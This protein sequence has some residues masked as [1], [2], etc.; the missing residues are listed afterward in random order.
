MF[1]RQIDNK[2][3]FRCQEILCDTI[4]R[5]P[6]FTV[7]RPASGISFMTKL[8]SLLILA[9][10]QILVLSLWFSVTAV[11]PQIAA[12]FNLSTFQ[13]GALTSAVIAG[14]VA[15]C[16]ISAVLNLADNLEPRKFFLV[17]ALIGAAANM[18]FLAVDAGSVLALLLRLLTGAVMAGV[19]PIGMKIAVSWAKNDAGLLVGFLVAALTVGSATPYLFAFTGGTDWQVV[20][21]Y[22]SIAS[23]IG[24]LLVML[25][26]IGPNFRKSGKF[27]VKRVL[28]TWK[29]PSIRLANFGYY[30]HMW[31]LYAV[32]A[33]ISFY[34]TAN[35]AHNG[36]DDPIGSGRL[37]GFLAIS[38]GFFGALLGGLLADRIGRTALTIGSLVVSGICCLLAGPLFGAGPAI[39]IGLAFVW[40]VSVIADSAQFS[41]SVAELSEP[42]NQGTMLTTQNAVGF[43]I[44]LVS[45]QLLPLWVDM[46][47]WEWAFAPLVLGPIFGIISMWRLRNHPDAVRMAGGRR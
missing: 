16:L 35:F 23:V 10:A 8:P 42:E 28:E 1:D 15:G 47:G 6:K 11:A 46:V 18:A 20:L 40:C 24:G 29:N 19:Y 44:A 31:E 2:L 14:F 36:V 27:D 7:R 26:R 34:L 25:V 17:C 12:E 39:V 37:W 9:F 43:A 32:W 13:Q 33:G 3:L 5:L 22:G 4:D 30:G 38:S 41:T 21:I 45:V